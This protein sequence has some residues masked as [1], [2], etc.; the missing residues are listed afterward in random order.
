MSETTSWEALSSVEDFLRFFD[1]PYNEHVVNV[2]RLHI[3]KKFAILMQEMDES[4]PEGTA[5]MDGYRN[6]LIQAY[7]TFLTSSATKERLFKVHQEYGSQP[8][9]FLAL[10]QIK[11]WASTNPDQ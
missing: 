1:I 4:T 11:G 5:R 2:N 9:Q 8:V 3:M 10:S 7:E 6:A